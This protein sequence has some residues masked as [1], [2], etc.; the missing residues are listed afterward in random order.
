MFE[1]EAEERAEK[2]EKN[3]TLGVYD[4]DEDLA[5]DEGFNDGEV[6]GYEKGFQDGAEF[7]YNK[8]NEW[9]KADVPTSP[10]NKVVLGYIKYYNSK[11]FCLVGWNGEWWYDASTYNDEVKLIAWKEIVLPE[12]KESE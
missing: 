3:Q 5:R 7:G 10:I 6:A 2:L 9:H 11:L 8:A 1:K 12:L 4:N